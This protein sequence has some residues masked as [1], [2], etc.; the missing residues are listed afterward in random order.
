MDFGVFLASWGGSG[1][2]PGSGNRFRVQFPEP[3]SEGCE[4]EV[5]KVSGEPE[6]LRRFLA[7]VPKVTVYFEAILFYFEGIFFYFE[8]ILVYFQTVRLYFE[9]KLV[10][11]EGTPCT[12]KVH[13]ATLK[14][15]LCA[16]KNYFCT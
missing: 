14:E 16:M 4:R 7:K 6:V 1:K 5:L 13:P 12:S 11:F 15:C 3:G 10:Y 2:E 9:S 8:N